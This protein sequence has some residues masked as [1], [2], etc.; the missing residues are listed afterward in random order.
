MINPLGIARRAAVLLP[1][2]APDLRPEGPLRAAQ[3]TEDGVW[4][5][6]ELPPFGFA[7]VPREA[8]VE[9]PPATAGALSV[10]DRVLRNES[11][12][13]EIDEATGGIRGIRSPREDTARIGERLVLS[14]LTGPD[15]SPAATRMRSESFEI[16]YAGPALVQAVARGTL[17]DPRDDR[18]LASFHQRYRLWTGRPILELDITLGDLDPDWLD[19]AAEADPWNHH[20]ACRWAWPDPDSMLRRTCLLAPELTEVDRPET[21]DAFDIS[22]RRQRTALLFG[23]LAHHRR[24]GTRMLDTLLIA[25]REASRTF[26]LGVVLDLEHPF[27]AAVDLIT[28]AFVVPTDAG[29]PPTGPTGWLF[30]LDTKAVA[31][32]RVEYAD[33]SGD[34]RGWGVVFH[35]VETAGTPARCRLRTFRNPVWARQIDFQNEPIVD[36]TVDGD[37]VLIDL[38]PHEIA[39]VDV[40]LG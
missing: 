19:R 23:G 27:H 35:L 4:A 32:T 24:H 20:L 16:D 3:F 34:G 18:R 13:V 12:V 30:H 9:V 38:T 5:V 37:A 21:P 25:G 1:D 33:P 6:V 8:H 26:R 40:T 11:L 28:P 39:R 7:W 2:A 10:R 31:V 22:T 36:L 17:T 15:G 29:P 14:G